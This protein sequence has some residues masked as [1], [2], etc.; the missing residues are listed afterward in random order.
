MEDTL[1]IKEVF[2]VF[3]KR[4]M[5]ICMITILAAFT[6]GIIT[7]YFITP[8]YQSSTQLLVNQ[9]SKEEFLDVNQVRTNIE[10]INTYSV[11]IKSPKI[12]K[13][14]VNELDLEQSVIELSEQVTV[15][16][17]E[18]S[19]VIEIIVETDNPTD[20]AI[21]ADGIAKVFQR[22]IVNIMKVDNV[23]VL[24]E[25]VE[26]PIPVKPDMIINVMIALIL[27]LCCGVGLAFLLEYLDTTIKNEKD[28]EESLGLMIIGHIPTIKPN[29]KTT[30]QKGLQ[31]Q[32][33]IGG[34]TLES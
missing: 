9:Q 27:G 13:E 15:K 20:S 12:L 32:V 23:T 16:D 26:N 8:T 17:L 25:A 1:N 6:S 21:I 10:L 30:K 34:Q 11:I 18:N 3:K 4:I 5:L 22:E 33:G 7:Y 24:F 31:N 14:V 28:I 2:N 29:K 19:Q